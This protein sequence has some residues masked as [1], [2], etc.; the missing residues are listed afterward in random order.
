M[1]M[2]DLAAMVTELTLGQITLEHNGG[3]I[4]VLGSD[5]K[6]LSVDDLGKTFASAVHATN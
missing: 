3:S 5:G 4:P 6:V 1:T 2:D